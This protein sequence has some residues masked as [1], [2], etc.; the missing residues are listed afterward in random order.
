VFDDVKAATGED[1]MAVMELI[2]GRNF[3]T[4]KRRGC[5]DQQERADVAPGKGVDGF[6]LEFECEKK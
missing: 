5:R 1:G 2:P 3:V 4:L 6:K